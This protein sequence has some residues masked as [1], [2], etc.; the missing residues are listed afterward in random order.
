ML[1]EVFEDLGDFSRQV[2]LDVGSGSGYLVSY[3][4]RKIGH[5]R[6]FAI[7]LFT[8]TLGLLNQK[9]SSNEMLKVIF[10]K[11]DLRKLDFLKN[12]FFDLITAYDT[13]SVVEKFTPEG[14]EHVLNEVYRILK[15]E[16]SFVVVERWPIDLIRPID[17]AQKVGAEFLSMF[18]RLDKALGEPAGVEY[19]PLSLVKTIENS[20]FK[21]SRWKELRTGYLEE[22]SGFGSYITERVQKVSDEKSRP[23]LLQEI[24]NID[25]GGKKHG[26]RTIPHYVVY[27]RKPFSAKRRKAKLPTLKKLYDTVHHKDLL[28][29]RTNN[30]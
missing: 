13:L 3:L 29:Y 8:G 16:G 4:V 30:L 1:D 19:T 28:G 24:E 14:T 18:V 27:A 23:E 6:V 21:V 5:E 15:P 9:L 10:I 11:A 25:R 7:D 17:E 2:S 20:G 26:M 12:C 22:Y